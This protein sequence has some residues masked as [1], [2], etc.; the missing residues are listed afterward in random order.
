MEVGGYSVPVSGVVHVGAHRGEELENY[1]VD[2]VQRAVW[3]EPNPEVY[4]EM[5]THFAA[6]GWDLEN[7]IKNHTFMLAASDVD[8]QEV[9]FYLVYG[10]DAGF[11]EGNKGCSSMLKPIGRFESWFQK[12]ITATTVT[13]DTLMERNNLDPSDYQCLMID[14]QGAE[15]LV[16]RGAENL[17]KHI[18][19]I[20]AEVTFHTPDYEDNPTFEEVRDFLDAHGFSHVTTGF[21][22]DDHQGDGVFI[23]KEFA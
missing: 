12:K 11:M 22:G 15:L 16:L 13:L 4:D 8:D 14:T 6:Y 2:G 1:I 5:M 17:L 21:W 9:D 20:V 18:T 7:R 19:L 23:R 10:P 3:I